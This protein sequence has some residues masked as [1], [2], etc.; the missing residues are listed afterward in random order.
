MNSFKKGLH[1]LSQLLLIM[2]WQSKPQQTVVFILYRLWPR[3]G[4]ILA[5]LAV[6]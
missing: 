3:G 1:F 6:Y 2:E 4:T 5:R